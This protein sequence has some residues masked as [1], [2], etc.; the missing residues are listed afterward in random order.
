MM[1]NEAVLTLF[2]F[3]ELDCPMMHLDGVSDMG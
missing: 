3:V 2:D 1:Q